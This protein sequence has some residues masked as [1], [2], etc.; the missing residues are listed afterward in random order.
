MPPCARGAPLGPGRRAGVWAVAASTVAIALVLAI[1]IGTGSSL[2]PVSSPGQ[3]S[4]GSS[5]IGRV[6]SPTLAPSQ[7]PSDSLSPS[8]SPSPRG[9]IPPAP[10]NGGPHLL[11]TADELR[12]L[13]TSGPAWAQLREWAGRSGVSP[14]IHDQN[15][16]TDLVALAKAFVYGRTRDGTFRHQAARLIRAAVGT[17][18]GG[19]TLALAR[20][21]PGYVIAADV[22]DLPTYD[23][24]FDRTVFRPWLRSLLTERLDDE[25]L[26]ATHE[27]RPNNWGTHA[28]AA[29]VA[30]AVYLGDATELSRA[31][32]VFRGWLGDRT[33]Y[34]GFV[35]GDQWWQCDPA[36]P[37]GIDPAGC[38]RGGHSLDGVLP[39]DQR[40]SGAFRWPPP[41]ENYVWEAL[42]GALLQAEL[43]QRAGYPAWSWGDKAL[44]RAVRWLYTVDRFPAGGDDA[45]AP[46]L[47]DRRFG[48]SFHGSSPA[49]PG[50][51]F[52]FT[53]WLYGR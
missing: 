6:E 49:R 24:T 46:W 34:A 21:L 51:N 4:A 45:W 31:A 43:L 7:T 5:A 36:H 30:I 20:N 26:T 29:R 41:K 15:D 17:E 18:R 37:V 8:P 28:G 33:A 23:P 25:T 48:T 38:Q 42:Q 35:W 27:L 11:V 40:R 50:K 44:L 10:L 39:D 32:A 52:G 47:V 2:G 3:R 13:P 12:A 22:I 14:M 19:R 16:D 53:D 1:L 9:S